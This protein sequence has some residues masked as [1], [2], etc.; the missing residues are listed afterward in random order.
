MAFKNGI[1]DG[2]KLSFK[3]IAKDDTRYFDML[4]KLM[5]EEHLKQ[6]EFLD[7]SSAG[8]LWIVQQYIEN[9]HL[10]MVEKDLRRDVVSRDSHGALFENTRK[11][12]DVLLERGESDIV[13]RTYKAAIS[14]R[15]KAI[16]EEQK[17]RDK[18]KPSSQAHQ[19]SAKWVK[20]YY[21]AL[22][23]MIRDYTALVDDL[24]FEE[25]ELETFREKFSNISR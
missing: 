22:R 23:D 20:L 3:S 25:S 4:F 5:E 17:L 12:L 9:G 13:V 14:H 8:S 16:T 7:Y 2:F 10:E 6:A 15:L 24:K 21:P 19:Q 1:I 11:I 18:S